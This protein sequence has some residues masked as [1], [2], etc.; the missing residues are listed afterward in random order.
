[1]T[2]DAKETG[3][4][5]SGRSLTEVPVDVRAIMHLPRLAQSLVISVRKQ[6]ASHRELNES[7]T[8]FSKNSIEPVRRFFGEAA[9]QAVEAMSK[10]RR[11]DFV[12]EGNAWLN[13]LLAWIYIRIF[14]LSSK[15]V[16]MVDSS[17]DKEH[18][19]LVDSA[20][21]L[22]KECLIMLGLQ[23][24]DEKSTSCETTSRESRVLIGRTVMG[25][26]HAARDAMNICGARSIIG[27][28]PGLYGA[29]ACIDIASG[30]LE[31]NMDA[32]PLVAPT[33]TCTASGRTTYDLCGMT[34]LLR[35]FKKLGLRSNLVFI[36]SPRM[37]PNSPHVAVSKL[38]YGVGLWVG[39]CAAYEMI[40][41]LVQPHQW[42]R[43]MFGGL[44]KASSD[45][46]RHQA[47]KLRKQR[48]VLRA[49]ELFPEVTLR[50]T[51]RSRV[52]DHN[53]ADA[54]LLAEYGRLI[55]AG[56]DDEGQKGGKRHEHKSNRRSRVGGPG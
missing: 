13:E 43:M 28:D 29:I 18:Q 26:V 20:K 51:E 30:S 15:D 54:L 44:G 5:K 39:M 41:T 31:R 16:P 14:C 53:M 17:N 21:V 46:T 2:H 19:S 32:E 45:L 23:A 49:K 34:L 25:S 50:R 22:V 55:I 1:M 33:P 52:P 27:I 36:E 4:D 10:D 37:L 8:N 6:D 24:D 38:Y 9:I 3:L 40:V 56:L 7:Y 48:S 42:Q 12:R 47:E 35:S 11:L